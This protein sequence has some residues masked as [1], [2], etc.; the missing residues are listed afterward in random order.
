MIFFTNLKRSVTH[1]PFLLAIMFLTPHEK[2]HHH[3]RFNHHHRHFITLTVPWFGLSK[4]S[5]PGK[6]WGLW[7]PDSESRTCSVSSESCRVLEGL[8]PRGGP[9]EMWKLHHGSVRIC[10]YV[11]MDGW[12]HVYIR[13]PRPTQGGARQ[14]REVV[15]KNNMFGCSKPFALDMISEHTLGTFSG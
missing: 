1:L 11:W 6:L 5:Q 4:R 10:M 3:G 12:M 7:G 15:N 14:G 2:P 9:L 13:R 8:A